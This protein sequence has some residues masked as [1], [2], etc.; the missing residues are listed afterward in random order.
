[1]RRPRR[2]CSDHGRMLDAAQGPIR[3]ARR[4]ACGN[5][6]TPGD[7]LLNS[8]RASKGS[9]HDVRWA[10]GS[11]LYPIPPPS[12]TTQLLSSNPAPRARTSISTKIGSPK[13]LSQASTLHAISVPNRRRL[14]RGIFCPDCRKNGVPVG[15]AQRSR[16]ASTHKTAGNGSRLCTWIL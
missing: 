1:V 4:R 9:A 6:Q 13:G 5:R 8:P 15:V 11:G 14:A 2:R 12:G 7:D 10:N 16:R 3:S